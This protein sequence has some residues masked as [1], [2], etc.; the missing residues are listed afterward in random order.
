M[1]HGCGSNLNLFVVLCFFVAEGQRTSWRSAAG[2]K[3][4]D[5][6]LGQ[7][8]FCGLGGDLPVSP[9]GVQTIED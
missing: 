6:G 8:A 2:W 5:C 1:F 4:S 9:A 7:M 3:C